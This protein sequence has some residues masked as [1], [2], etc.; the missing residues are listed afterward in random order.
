MAPRPGPPNAKILHS[1]QY[2]NVYGALQRILI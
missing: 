1:L 2:L